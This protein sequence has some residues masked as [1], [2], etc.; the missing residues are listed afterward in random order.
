LVVLSPWI[1]LSLWLLFP[2]NQSKSFLSP[3]YE[4]LPWCLLFVFILVTPFMQDRQ[5]RTPLV[6]VTALSLSAKQGKPILSDPSVSSLLT[7][8]FSIYAQ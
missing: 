2:M 3:L 6:A 1:F 4:A 7:N 8:V 5:F